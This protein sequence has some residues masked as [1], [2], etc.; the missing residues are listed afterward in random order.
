MPSSNNSS[1]FK[2][3]EKKRKSRKR[4]TKRKLNKKLTTVYATLELCRVNKNGRKERISNTLPLYID[5]KYKFKKNTWEYNNS[6]YPMNSIQSGQF[7][8]KI[9]DDYYYLLVCDDDLVYING[10]IGDKKAS[11]EYNRIYQKHPDHKI[12]Y[13]MI[14]RNKLILSNRID[15]KAPSLMIKYRTLKKQ[16]ERHVKRVGER[17]HG[18]RKIKDLFRRT[19]KHKR[20]KERNVSSESYSSI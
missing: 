12:D 17:A 20:E 3:R 2:K 9:D 15:Y 18:K 6:R 8:T 11:K 4:L 14:I 16:F 13:S 19:H 7:I 10:P 5:P 1:Y